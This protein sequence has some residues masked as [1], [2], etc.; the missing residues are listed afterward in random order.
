MLDNLEDFSPLRN[1]VVLVRVPETY[2]TNGKNSF[3][4]EFLGTED[5]GIDDDPTQFFRVVAKGPKTNIVDINDIVVCM[6]T[7]ITPPEL[8]MYEGE[9]VKFG[10]TSEDELLAVIEEEAE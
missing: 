8:G 7:R 6:W 1:D 10:I 9:R 5:K 4:T 2:I 3:A